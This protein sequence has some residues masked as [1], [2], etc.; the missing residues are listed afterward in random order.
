MAS[1]GFAPPPPARANAEVAT[2]A[3]ATTPTATAMA[4]QDDG[5]FPAGLVEALVADLRALAPR[6]PSH[7]VGPLADALRPADSWA[8]LRSLLRV[9]LGPPAAV[10]ARL[11]GAA[12]GRQAALVVLAA[13]ERLG[14]AN[15]ARECA[16]RDRDW[17]L[18]RRTAAADD[19]PVAGDAVWSG[20]C[21]LLA[22]LSA[23]RS[24]IAGE[25]VPECVPLAFPRCRVGFTRERA[26]EAEAPRR[27]QSFA[28]SRYCPRRQDRGASSRIA[29]TFSWVR[30]PTSTW[31]RRGRRRKV[32]LRSHLHRGCFWR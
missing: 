9:S 31:P 25:I 20:F 30:A 11:D 13:L 2:T 22:W 14:P 17:L 23:V 5:E 32:R 28:D 10:F 7:R 15:L 3:S 19:E 26:F 21:D 18:A 12:T 6:D 1:N 29:G 24:A 27:T 8:S 16:S 4:T